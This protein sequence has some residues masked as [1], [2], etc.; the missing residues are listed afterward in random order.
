[1][2]SEEEAIQAIE[3]Y[4]DMVKR[5]CMLHLKNEQDTE[6]IFQTVFLK[7]VLYSGTFETAEHEKAWLIRVTINA[8][9]DLLKSFYRKLL[10]LEETAGIASTDQG[11][12]EV[13]DIIFSLPP[14]YKDVVYLFY[15]EGYTA[16]EIAKILRKKENT[17][18]SLLSRARSLLREEIGGADF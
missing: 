5:I 17:I 16:G 11:Y 15:Y 6:D 9:K 1:M 3:R 12:S 18:Y 13:L 10:P 2:K 4:A 8:C 14:K 7:Y